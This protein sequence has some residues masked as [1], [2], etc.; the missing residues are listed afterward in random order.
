MVP[1]AQGRIKCLTCGYRSGN[2]PDSIERHNR[3]SRIV[4]EA[5]ILRAMARNGVDVF[6]PVQIDLL[7]EAVEE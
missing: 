5:R 6:I 7:C 2:L 1:S 4:T 3:V